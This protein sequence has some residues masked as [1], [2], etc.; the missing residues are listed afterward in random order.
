MAI[1]HREKLQMH[2]FK[3]HVNNIFN[4]LSKIKNK[5]KKIDAVQSINYN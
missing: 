1:I 5:F 4:I 3:R 2:N